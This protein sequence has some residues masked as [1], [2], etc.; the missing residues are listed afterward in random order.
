MCI[1][2]FHISLP[3]WAVN[4]RVTGSLTQSRPP[5]THLSWV[6]LNAIFFFFFFFFSLLLDECVLLLWYHNHDRNIAFSFPEA[7]VEGCHPLGC[8]ALGSDIP[9]SQAGGHSSPLMRSPCALGDPRTMSPLGQVISE[10]QDIALL[11]HLASCLFPTW[12]SWPLSLLYWAIAQ[13]PLGNPEG[14]S[15]WWLRGL[16]EIRSIC[17]SDLEEFTHARLYVLRTE[18]T[19]GWAVWVHRAPLS[20]FLSPCLQTVRLSVLL[21]LIRLKEAKWKG[22]AF[23]GC[24]RSLKKGVPGRP[25]RREIVVAGS[26]ERGHLARL[27]LHLFFIS[28]EPTLGTKCSLTDRVYMA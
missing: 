28:G 21:N 2:L 8:P 13:G 19:E 23:S 15:P 12:S 18:G 4:G 27:A 17:S 11:R 10:P 6:N 16:S 20:P 14:L 22:E 1:C 9:L 24:K 25:R 5:Q 26:G 7:R 3:H